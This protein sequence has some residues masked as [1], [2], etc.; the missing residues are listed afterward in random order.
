MST[1][2]AFS[3]DSLDY[4]QRTG[5][6]FAPKSVGEESSPIGVPRLLRVKGV[7]RLDRKAQL[8]RR[9]AAVSDWQL[10][11]LR[12]QDLMTGLHTL[13]EP[14]IFMVE[15]DAA[16]TTIQIGTVEGD[17]GR[18]DTLESLRAILDSVYPGVTADGASTTAGE[19]WKQA[20]LVLGVPTPK[21]PDPTDGAYALD[22]LIR[23][24]AGAAWK[25]VVVAQPVPESF[26]RGIRGKVIAEMRAMQS[27]AVSARAPS[28]LAEHYNRVLQAMLE[29]LAHAQRVG[30]WRTAGYLLAD[31]GAFERLAGNWRAAFSGESSLPEPVRVWRFDDA[32]GLANRC[33][34]PDGEEREGPGLYTHPYRYQTLLSS[35]QVAAYVHLPQVET[36]GF[37]VRVIPD[38]DVN[39]GAA[40]SGS[41]I[42]I[43][44]IVQRTRPTGLSYSVPAK[45]LS[46]H[47]FVTGVTGSGKTNTVFQMLRN[48]AKRRIPFLVVEPSKTEYRALLADAVVGPGLRVFTFGDEAEA[49][50]RLNPFQAIQG[51]PIGVHIDL[52]RAVFSAS[53]A[54]WVPLP[55]VLERAIIGAYE[56]RGWN[57]RD[58]SNRRLG[59]EAWHADAYP[60]LEEVVGKVEELVPTLGFDPEAEARILASLTSRLNGL[61]VGGKG[62]L[63]DTRS[64]VSPGA[65][66]GRPVIAELDAIADDDDKAFLIGLLVI[67]LL[68]HSRVVGPSDLRH[69]LVIE[70][71]HRLLT[72]VPRS[73]SQEQADPRGKAVE[74]FT[75]LLS[76]IRAYGQGIVIVDQVPSRLAP[77]VIKNTN[78]KVGHRLV[79]ADDREVLGRSMAMTGVQI[80]SM[81]SFQVGNAAVFAGDVDDAPLLVEVPEVEALAVSSA[82]NAAIRR[83]ALAEQVRKQTAELRDEVDLNGGA[84]Q[85]CGSR[86]MAASCNA[87][88]VLAR[89]RAVA[90][91]IERLA[92]SLLDT[93]SSGIPLWEDVRR[94]VTALL[95]AG[96]PERASIA[97]LVD[98]GARVYADLAGGQRSWSFAETIEF[99][100]YLSEVLAAL[101]VGT[102][103]AIAD[104]VQAYCTLAERLFR[105]ET[106]PLPACRA[107][108]PDGS[109]R[110]RYATLSW[111]RDDPEAF[112]VAEAITPFAS[113]AEIWG[114]AAQGGWAVTAMDVEAAVADADGAREASTRAGLCLAQQAIFG[115][116]RMHPRTADRLL[117]E[118]FVASRSASSDDERSDE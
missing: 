57:I 63:L 52:L 21:T 32:V 109:C 68:E 47:T 94:T 104:A 10:A 107:I 34:M 80:E 74:T 37:S 72:N 39:P 73:G 31:R 59:G 8:D 66:L 60:T 26:T 48:L 54:M 65:L 18:A 105:R 1:K 44:G 16:G 42:P 2:P 108:C 27:S 115:K 50:C 85:A 9:Q 36:P 92:V 93:R 97:C 78:L 22:R 13:G 113:G 51:I 29:E 30:G 61:R 41:S 90:L 76:E 12:S 102:Q 116:S 5:G 86:G 67:R 38:F 117:D 81:A 40:D 6:G 35:A 24:M 91:R 110:Y 62:A 23:G 53:F 25:A 14:V 46:S 19:S 82:K 71:A 55:Q 112:S 17:S 106:D 45:A 70:E 99:G 84:C 111:L 49:P 83:R 33:S 58:G 101:S 100:D 88:K 43:G 7:G 28:P 11:H 79:A 3:T 69:V 114:F 20:G 4:I 64:A 89:H 96:V 118:V 95:P 56:E 98:R 75:N 15:G 87:G 103:D 77:D